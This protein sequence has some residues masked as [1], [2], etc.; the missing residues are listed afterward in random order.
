MFYFLFIFIYLFSFFAVKLK[1]MNEALIKYRNST[2][3]PDDLYDTIFSIQDN[4]N[5]ELK[6]KLIKVQGYGE[7]GLRPDDESKSKF[8]DVKN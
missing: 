4:I 8:P 6:A 5:D 2:E 3:I 7:I 1:S